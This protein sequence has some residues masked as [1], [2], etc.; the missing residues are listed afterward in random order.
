MFKQQLI[1]SHSESILNGDEVHPKLENIIS[2][3]DFCMAIYKE[4]IS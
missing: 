3:Q 1:T 4:Q 2:K